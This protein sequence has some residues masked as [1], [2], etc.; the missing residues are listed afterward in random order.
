MPWPFGGD[1]IGGEGRNTLPDGRD[2]RL[3]LYKYDTCPYCMRVFRAIDRLNVN[4]E[5][6][7][8]HRDA[9]WSADLRAHT[10]MTQVPCLKIDD[11]YMHESSDIIAWL[12]AHFPPKSTA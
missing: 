5:Y 3:A 7:D 12:D 6:R 4:V 2:V 9:P 10:G 8:T 1:R 11:E